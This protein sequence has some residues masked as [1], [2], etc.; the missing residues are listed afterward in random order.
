MLRKFKKELNEIIAKRTVFFL[1]CIII[2]VVILGTIAFALVEGWHLFDAFYFTTVT[3]ATVGYGDM[4]PVTY[5]GKV[6]SIIYGFMW[7]PLFIGL[8]WFILQSKF[9]QM[10]KN[11][12]HSYHQEVKETEQIALQNQKEIKKDQKK[13][14]KIEKKEK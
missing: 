3:M 10:V 11:S 5:G 2:G 13:I 12:I 14:A 6:L 1:V 4:A 9:H 8:T 7:A